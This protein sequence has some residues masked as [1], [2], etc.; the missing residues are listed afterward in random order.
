MKGWL[1]GKG[2]QFRF[3]EHA[4]ARKPVD[5]ARVRG[6]QLRQ[7]AKTLLYIVDGKPLLVVL[8]GDRSVDEKR[9]VQIANAKLVRL[10]SSEE[11]EKHTGC[12]V[13][14]VP[15]VIDGVKKIFDKPLFSNNEISFN[16]GIETA[17]IIIA[18]QKLLNAVDNYSVEQVSGPAPVMGLEVHVQLDT[19]SKLFCGCS[20][21]EAEPNSHC[22]E[23][24][25]GM[26]GSKPVL[27]RKAVDFAL[28]LCLALGCRVNNE[29]FFSRKT[30]FYP[31]L[32]K[33]YQITQFEIPVGENGSVKL[34]SGKT[35]RIRRI[36]LEEDPAAL[37][38]EGGIHGSAYSL[39]DY[40]RSG[41][42]LCE[43]VTEPDFG[44]PEETREFLD[45]LL[46]MLEY[47][48]VFE[49]GKNTLKVDS[50]AS[51][52][53]SERVEVKNIS[54][55]RFVE[56]AL[57]FEIA[58]QRK[59]LSA[60]KKVERETRSFDEKGLVTKR[61]R[62]K[63][64]E[65]DYGYIFD[66]DL[67]K[68]V[69]LEAELHE[70]KKGLPELHSNKAGRFGREFGLDD[71]TAKVLSSDAT[72]G[73]LFEETAKGVEPKLAASFL[74]RELLAIANRSGLDLKRL[75]LEPAKIAG[76]LRLL[77]Q[78]KVSEKN[79][80]EAMI[81][82]VNEKAEP[83]DFL[84]KNDLLKDAGSGDVDAAI[85]RVVAANPAAAADYKNGGEKALN[86]LV[87]LAMRELRG[88]ADAKQLG[89]KF[90]KLLK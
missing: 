4:P 39:I 65:D 5:S 86:F 33:D 59:V 37:V 31:D 18:P 3:L 58:R 14:L 43:I 11:V 51:I 68:T 81:A 22:C 38:H 80:K 16:A 15:P 79:A 46:K 54:G 26:P 32:A 56:K 34:P 13:G 48:E 66:S 72:L 25:L 82:Y 57:E 44:K 50:N 90:A 76:L 23:T 24:C 60:G 63:E 78:G 62:L 29:F 52:E 87:G 49:Q 40:N 84:K 61:L 85:A 45:E 7:I 28:K 9:L 64:T 20:T 30:Y 67:V 74:T 2:L 73:R 27:N 47:L 17:G 19:Q 70:I 88:K 36:H 69:V 55:F 75:N 8:S 21:A 6:V 83:L 35:I 41:I 1:E 12:V 10:A 42:P 71:Y 77:E 53:G 89:E